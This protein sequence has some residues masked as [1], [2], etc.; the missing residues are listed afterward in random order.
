MRR[1]LECGDSS[2]LCDLWPLFDGPQS[3]GIAVMNYRTPKKGA[4]LVM[5]L[6]VLAV[7]TAIFLASLKLLVVQ[8]Q[9]IELES[10]RI[11]AGW[12][13]QSGVD[14]AAARLAAEPQYRGET[15]DISAEDL[16]GRDGGTVAIRIENVSGKP[17]RRRLHVVADYPS[18]TEQRARE[19]REVTINVSG[20]L[21]VPIPSGTRSVPDTIGTKP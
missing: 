18:D 6:I 10:Q 9:S 11:Q 16:G 17:D 1:Y 3:G 8:R 14:R 20:T 21:R 2:P 5:I 13:A 7:A 19:T 4:A 12:L 15:W